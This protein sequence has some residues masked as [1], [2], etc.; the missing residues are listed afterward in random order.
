MEE[1]QVN[2]VVTFKKDDCPIQRERIF[3]CGTLLFQESKMIGLSPIA[4]YAFFDLQRVLDNGQRG[5]EVE[6]FVA[7]APSMVVIDHPSK[8]FVWF[9]NEKLI[10]ALKE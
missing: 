5:L 3:D 7:K 10:P 6:F 1:I 9:I 8:D 4:N 2:Y